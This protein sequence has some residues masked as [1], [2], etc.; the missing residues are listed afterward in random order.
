M[1]PSRWTR[2]Y[3]FDILRELDIH[4]I[5]GAPGTNEIP[6]IDGTA[7]ESNHVSYIE[8]LHEN[9]AIG[10][11]MGSAPPSPPPTTDT[12]ALAATRQAR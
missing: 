9:I 5:F 12:R 1:A 6:I 11:A 4:Y 3:V 10:A 7:I 8:C 2:D